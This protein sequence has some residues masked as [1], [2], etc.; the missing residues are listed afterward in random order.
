MKRVLTAALA[1]SAAMTAMGVSTT[2][3]AATTINGLPTGYTTTGPTTGNV[4]NGSGG[5]NNCYAQTNGTVV[6]GNPGT[7]GSSPLIARINAT[8]TNSRGIT[9]ISTLFP[10]ING[11][12]FNIVYNS[13]A[14]TLSFTY[15]PGTN[16]PVIHYLGI[17]QANMYVLLYDVSSITSGTIDLTSYFP[18]NPGFSHIDIFDTGAPG[19]PE[20]ATWAMMLLGF[21]GIGMTMRRKRRNLMQVA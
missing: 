2:A 20:P 14:N 18:N 13:T 19:V 15:T 12:E 7:A 17:S 10:S 21:G 1:A 9:E 16:D 3:Q 5:I 11:Q 6:N 4:C 8:P